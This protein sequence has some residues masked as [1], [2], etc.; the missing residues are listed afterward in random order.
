MHKTRHVRQ[1]AYR[2]RGAHQMVGCARARPRNLHPV[3]LLL[4]M[5]S[6][7]WMQV[8]QGRAPRFFPGPSAPAQVPKSFCNHDTPSSPLATNMRVRS[9]ITHVHETDL[10]CLHPIY[11]FPRKLFIFQRVK[12]EYVLAN[13]NISINNARIF[14]DSLLPQTFLNYLIWRVRNSSNFRMLRAEQN[15]WHGML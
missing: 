5:G 9:R 6:L 13:F 15:Q 4:G 7:N 8:A 2:I 1:I 12:A 10:P 14:K 11:Q 3:P